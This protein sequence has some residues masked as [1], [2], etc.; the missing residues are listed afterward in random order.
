MY[1][2]QIIYSLI[3]NVILAKEDMDGIRNQSE[4]IQRCVDFV[5]AHFD[6]PIKEM[7]NSFK[8]SFYI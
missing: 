6:P 4:S 5:N 2:L 7:G 1:P 8:A 3:V